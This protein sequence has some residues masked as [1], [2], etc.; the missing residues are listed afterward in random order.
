V[1]LLP[2]CERLRAVV[3]GTATT[4]GDE[5]AGQT[6]ADPSGCAV[7]RL[8]EGIES[9]LDYLNLS[10]NTATSATS[11]TEPPADVGLVELQVGG[12]G[13]GLHAGRVRRI[14]RTICAAPVRSDSARAARSASVATVWEP[15]RW[16][17]IGSTGSAVLLMKTSLPST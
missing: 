6:A 10:E 11:A 7:A 13:A 3:E 14:P 17:R 15:W 1:A 9:N 12:D 2:G 4:A 16:Q 5:T 8:R